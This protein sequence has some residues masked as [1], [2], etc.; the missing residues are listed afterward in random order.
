MGE[1][2]SEPVRRGQK[3]RKKRALLIFV[4]SENSKKEVFFSTLGFS[5]PD[6]SRSVALVVS[7][8]HAVLGLGDREGNAQGASPRPP[9]PFPEQT[10]AGLA[11][12][13]VLHG[14]LG[15]KG[16]EKIFCLP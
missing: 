2:A 3:K 12:G 14:I 1:N 5:E 16:E 13:V 11:V 4:L 9:S 6:V 15:K 7:G 8:L 10:N